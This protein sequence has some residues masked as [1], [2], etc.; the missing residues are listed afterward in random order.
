VSAYSK[1]ALI[2]LKRFNWDTNRGRSVQGVQITWADSFQP[3]L[4][5][6]KNS[7]LF[8]IFCCYYNL[9][10]IYFTRALRLSEIDLDTSRKEGMTK[11]KYAAFLIGEMKDK[12]YGEFTQVGFH[13]TQFPHLDM[14]QNL[15]MGVIYKCLFNTFRESEYKLGINK[16]AAIAATAAKYYNKAYNA[17]TAFFQNPSGIS[18]KTKTELL[19]LSYLESLYFDTVANTKYAKH[20]NNLLENDHSH[21][22]TVIAY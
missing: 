16:I 5:F 18:D 3:N 2:I 20:Y 7:I 15:C 4:E 11:A 19:S 13:D 9:A 10:I 6:T 17:G 12:Y 8:D 22:A 1:Y 14:L 21:I